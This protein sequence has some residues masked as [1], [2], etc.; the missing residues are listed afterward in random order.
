MASEYY[1]RDVKI[2]VG[3]FEKNYYFII[4]EWKVGGR[5]KTGKEIYEAFHVF[6]Y[7]ITARNVETKSCICGI[8]EF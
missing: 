8:P 2:I 1:D 4:G 7:I 3:L 6:R 5:K